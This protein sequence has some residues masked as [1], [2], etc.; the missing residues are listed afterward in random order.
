MATAETDF[1]DK[2]RVSAATIYQPAPVVGRP[3][4][5]RHAPAW[6]FEALTAG[7]GDH[8]LIMVYA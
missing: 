4:L 6:F 2:K 8:G 7:T 5:A 3:L 1:A